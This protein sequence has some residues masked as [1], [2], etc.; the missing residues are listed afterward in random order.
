MKPT[1]YVAAEHSLLDS[2]FGILT[3]ALRRAVRPRPRLLV[4]VPVIVPA[5]VK[6]VLAV[7]EVHHAPRTRHL[8]PYFCA[9]QIFTPAS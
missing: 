9:L 3:D 7:R 1:P 8:E 5:G 6:E 4:A 2:A